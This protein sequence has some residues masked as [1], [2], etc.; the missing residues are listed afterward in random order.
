MGIKA[1]YSDVFVGMKIALSESE[2]EQN[3]ENLMASATLTDS[4]ERVIDATIKNMTHEEIADELGMS[5]SSVK[6]LEAK[7]IK[8]MQYHTRKA[9]LWPDF[10]NAE[11]L[12]KAATSP[13]EI[14]TV[15]LPIRQ[16][17]DSIFHDKD[18]SGMTG[19]E[20]KIN[21][22]GMFRT[23]NYSE[24]K[25]DIFLARYVQGKEVKELA[26]T[27]FYSK[28]YIHSIIKDITVLLVQSDDK[29][30]ALLLTGH[31]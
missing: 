13:N 6:Q 15:V 27:Y 20:M 5:L 17:Y 24:S 2:M 21:L 12:E 1:I 22:E 10:R 30:R 31:R 19:E 18:L 8:R 29:Q 26:E 4:E 11:P 28:G 16:L 14:K 7:A 25:K 3:F 23:W 9:I